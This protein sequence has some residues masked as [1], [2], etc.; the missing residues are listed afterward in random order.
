M[1]VE[2]DFITI[3]LIPSA[4]LDNA[5]LK[6]EFPKPEVL[7]RKM[8][9]DDPLACCVPGQNREYPFRPN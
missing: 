8:D 7:S 4:I 3:S 5:V 1:P 9:K 2:V 6:R